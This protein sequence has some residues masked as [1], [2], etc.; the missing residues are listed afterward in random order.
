MEIMLTVNVDDTI[1]LIGGIFSA[2]Y[3]VLEIMNWFS[4][5]T[6][7]FSP[8]KEIIMAGA[9]TATNPEGIKVEEIIIYEPF[10]KDMEQINELK[11]EIISQV[12]VKYPLGQNTQGFN[13]FN[14]EAFTKSETP[15][16]SNIRLPGVGLTTNPDKIINL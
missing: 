7:L 6:N 10:K 11:E 2:Y 9:I 16:L 12:A 13:G 14:K 5:I 8:N 15:D 3:L 4:T 1:V